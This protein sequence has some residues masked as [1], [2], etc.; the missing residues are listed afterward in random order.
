MALLLSVFGIIAIKVNVVELLIPT[1]INYRLFN[2][3][4]R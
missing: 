1:D 3:Y 2:F 4:R